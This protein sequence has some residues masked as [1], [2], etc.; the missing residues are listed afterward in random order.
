MILEMPV[1]KNQRPEQQHRNAW[2]FWHGYSEEN[3][4]QAGS[5]SCF[6]CKMDH[7]YSTNCKGTVLLPK[8]M[9]PKQNN[10]GMQSENEDHQ[11]QILLKKEEK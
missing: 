7:E 11:G 5:A 3:Y 8:A 9:G 1:K 10:N 4:K 2:E 6:Q